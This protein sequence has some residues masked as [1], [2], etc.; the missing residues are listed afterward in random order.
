MIKLYKPTKS[1]YT[2]HFYP[3]KLDNSPICANVND[4]QIKIVVRD[5]LTWFIINVTDVQLWD[6]RKTQDEPESCEH[7]D[8]MVYISTLMWRG[9]WD[10]APW[11][12]PS[13]CRPSE[14][15]N[16]TPAGEESNN[17]VHIYE[18]TLTADRRSEVKC[19]VLTR[20]LMFWSN[21]SDGSM[22]TL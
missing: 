17:T 8:P 14:N 1:N 21:R 15:R 3:Y 6:T 13:D 18:Y 5:K 2:S 12:P 19:V 11:T 16:R 10:Q 20:K 9:K 22:L 4:K 7:I